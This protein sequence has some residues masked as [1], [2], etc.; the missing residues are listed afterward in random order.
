MAG[1]KDLLAALAE[2]KNNKLD[3]LVLPNKENPQAI[4]KIGTAPNREIHKLRLALTDDL[5]KDKDRPEGTPSMF[6][7]PYNF[8]NLSVVRFGLRSVER[9][10]VTYDLTGLDVDQVREFL[11]SLPTGW[12]MAIIDKASY[13]FW[14]P[15]EAGANA[16]VS[17]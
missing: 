15:L 7:D 3:T 5:E 11:E 10:G 17:F 2:D 13:L 14:N 8:Y 9:D 4:F 16:D 12:D 6:A 1:F